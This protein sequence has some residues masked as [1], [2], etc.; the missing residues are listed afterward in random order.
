VMLDPLHFGGGNTTYEALAL[1][2]PIVHWPGEFM[3]GRVTTGC[4]Q[5]M[6]VSDCIVHSAQA[7]IELAVRLGTD[8]T[9]RARISQRILQTHAVLYEDRAVITEL[10]QFFLNALRRS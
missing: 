3:R 2:V 10:E 5:K 8:A 9:E 4:Y 7:Y 1:G 6:Q